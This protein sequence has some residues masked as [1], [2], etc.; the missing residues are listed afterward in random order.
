MYFGI[1]L[2]DLLN[3]KVFPNL[4]I[5]R[6]YGYA[7]KCNFNRAMSEIFYMRHKRSYRITQPN[8]IGIVNARSKNVVRIQQVYHSK[9][10]ET[11]QQLFTR[12]RTIFRAVS[13][14]Q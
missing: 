14:K 6:T 3:K 9:T 12:A 5:Q 4:I 13:K 8:A 10:T 11:D 2:R 1:A 7:G